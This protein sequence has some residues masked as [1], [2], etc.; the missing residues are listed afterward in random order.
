MHNARN[1]RLSR[2]RSCSRVSPS[3]LELELMLTVF[4]RGVT[5]L[6]VTVVV[7]MFELTGALTYVL[8]VMVSAR[9][10]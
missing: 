8:P 3:D 4:G 9:L 1:I 6:T 10:V 7:I 2:G 5:R